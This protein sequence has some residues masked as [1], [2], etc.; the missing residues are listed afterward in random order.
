M[1][2]NNL[3]KNPFSVDFQK[4]LRYSCVTKT[5]AENAPKKGETTMS[6]YET[7]YKKLLKRGF[8]EDEIDTEKLA[9]IISANYK[10]WADLSEKSMKYIMF[11]TCKSGF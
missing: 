3:N 9:C 2:S 11:Y 7:A 5:G 1:L 6:K 8:Y 10:G 4:P